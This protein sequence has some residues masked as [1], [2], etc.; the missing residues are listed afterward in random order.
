M[1]VK[2]KILFK[3]IL[4]L[5]IF[6]LALGKI[7]QILNIVVSEFSWLKWVGFGFLSGIFLFLMGVLMD[8]LVRKSKTKWNRSLEP[9][10][11]LFN[12]PSYTPENGILAHYRDFP[13][14]LSY[15]LLPINK[16]LK[17]GIQ[18]IISFK[19][20]RS[21][22]LYEIKKR[23][24]AEHLFQ[25]EHFYLIYFLPFTSHSMDQKIRDILDQVVSVLED[26]HVK[27][28]RDECQNC[29]TRQPD[30]Q[31][32]QHKEIPIYLCSECLS[33]LT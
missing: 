22:I 3:N 9:Y 21:D 31:F 4:S 11:S 17:K 8:Y 14:T 27:P 7:L 5:S 26:F 16:L 33:R 23:V 1:P 25:S 10:Q 28:D 6:F 29:H 2:L 12:N 13:V 32:I 24:P 20:I 19:P 18:L 15:H 30:I